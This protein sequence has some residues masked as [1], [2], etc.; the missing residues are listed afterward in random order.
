MVSNHGITTTIGKATTVALLTDSDFGIHQSG[1]GWS[2]LQGCYTGDAEHPLNCH[3][4]AL[5][6]SDPWAMHGG[7]P[8]TALSLTCN[9]YIHI[10]VLDAILASA[11]GL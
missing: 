1:L 8:Q 3:P 11:P 9:D 6:G 2:I 7:L 5:I 10:V 4:V